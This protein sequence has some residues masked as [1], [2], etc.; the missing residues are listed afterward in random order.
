MCSS[1]LALHLRAPARAGAGARWRTL[2]H[3]ARAFPEGSGQACSG[4]RDL[5]ALWTLPGCASFGRGREGGK[6]ADAEREAEF[7]RSRGVIVGG[8]RGGGASSR[9]QGKM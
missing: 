6:E 5:G 3:A 4:G 9:G 2:A 8:V 1:H 7:G